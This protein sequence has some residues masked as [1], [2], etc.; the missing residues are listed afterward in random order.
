MELNKMKCKIFSTMGQPASVFGVALMEIMKQNDKIMVL[1]AD[2]SNYAGL[3][4]FKDAYPDH[5][6]NMG[7]SE[8]NMIGVA[9]GMASEG[10]K[11]I[12]EAQSCFLSMR[13]FEQLRQYSGY[14]KFPIVFVGINAGLSLTYMGN[15]HFSVEDMGLVRNIPNMTIFS[16]CDAGEAVK[17]FD[18]ALKMNT[19]VYLRLMGSLGS[20]SIYKDDFNFEVGEPIELKEGDDIQILATGSMV[21]V[22]INASDLL[23]EK[24]I[25][26]QVLDVH[27]LK[28]FN[29]AVLSKTAK[30]IVTIEEHT[31]ISGLA[32][33]VSSYLVREPSHPALLSIGLKDEYGEVGEYPWMLEKRELTADI[34]VSKIINII[35]E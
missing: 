16:P 23:K 18:A 13:S 22:A 12:V 2:M 30:I 35:R 24:D 3:N 9:A 5:F 27:T 8:Q 15:T 20:K 14:M 28:P 1:S 7:I 11:V 25:N 34:V 10:Y 26:A 32:S 29:A 6:I 17:A 33:V 4:K 31:L 21:D 19:P